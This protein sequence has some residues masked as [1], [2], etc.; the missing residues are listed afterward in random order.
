M[1]KALIAAASSIALFGGAMTL[2]TPEAKASTPWIYVGESDNGRRDFVKNIRRGS[3]G[4]TYYTD[5]DNSEMA[6]NCG[7]GEYW[8]R[9]KNNG[10]WSSLGYYRPGS[11][12]HAEYRVVCEGARPRV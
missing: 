11:M 10:K 3:D 6:Y 9:G 2:I 1:K 5:G 12:G 7:T 8:L 4:F